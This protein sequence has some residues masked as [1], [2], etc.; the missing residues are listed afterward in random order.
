MMKWIEKILNFFRKKD[1]TRMLDKGKIENETIDINDKR[2]KFIDSLK[3]AAAD[4]RKKSSVKTIVCHGDGT[5]IDTKI[6]Y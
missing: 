1:T 2:K 3:T 6:D 5:G 4:I